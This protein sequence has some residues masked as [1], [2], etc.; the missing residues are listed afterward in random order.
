VTGPPDSAH[1]SA[2]WRDPHLSVAERVDDLLGRMTVAEKAHQLVGYWAAPARP[3][4]P[5]APHQDDFSVQAPPLDDV[6]A[7]GGLGSSPG[8]TAPRR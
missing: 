8:P 2:P 4:A 6:V 3:G 5:V 7:G 1:A